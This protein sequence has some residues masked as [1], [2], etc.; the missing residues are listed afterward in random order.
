MYYEIEITTIDEEFDQVQI[1]IDEE[2]F[3][4]YET[5]AE[6]IEYIKKEVKKFCKNVKE[7][8]I[9]EDTI[10]EIEQEIEDVY[11]ASD[12]HPNET[13]EDFME[14]EDF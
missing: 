8:H 6:K 9:D 10:E 4:E 7:F 14:H 12:M 2:E 13:Y 5:I 1:E 3:C 11:D